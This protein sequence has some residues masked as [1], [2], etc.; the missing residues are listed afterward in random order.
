MVAFMTGKTFRLAGI[1]AG[2]RRGG[3]FLAVA[4][5]AVLV[6][7]G[8]LAGPFTGLTSAAVATPLHDASDAEPGAGQ[9]APA[10]HPGP[11]AYGTDHGAGL[12]HQQTAALPT[13][14]LEPDTLVGLDQS[15]TRRLLGAPAATEVEREA[16][17]KVWRYARGGCTLKVFFFMD[18]TSQDFRALTYDMTSSHNVPN[19]DQRCFAH[20]VAQAW[21]GSHD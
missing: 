14:G 3:P 17:A 20:L 13:H 15:Q 12:W 5:L 7:S 6:G 9:R 1:D 11:S 8:G 19:D 16:P 10:R 18:M 4:A 2:S 21:V